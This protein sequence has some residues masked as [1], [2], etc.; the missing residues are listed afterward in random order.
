MAHATTTSQ[1]RRQAAA[2]ASNG[3]RPRRWLDR[4]S[5]N[6]LLKTVIAA[7]AAAVIVMLA[8]NAWDSW[9]KLR[10]A[11]EILAVAELSSHAFSAMNGLRTDRASTVR[12]L[13][14][15]APIQ[16]DMKSY[17]KKYRDADLPGARAVAEVVRKIEFKDQAALSAELD[18]SIKALAQLQS[19]SWD[20]LEKPKAARREQLGNEF[21]SETTKMLEV[22]DKI[23]GNAFA[24]IKHTNAY[25]DEMMEMK[26]LA[27]LV[28]NAGGEASVL[29]SNG[30]AAGKVPPEARQLYAGW[31]RATEQLWAALEDLAS[32]TQLP[33]PLASA[34]TGAKENYF[35]VKFTGMR[36]RLLNALINGEKPELTANQYSPISA[37]TRESLLAVAERALDAAKDQ[38]QALQVAAERQLFGQVML[39]ALALALAFGSMIAVN[40]RVVGP[41]RTICEAMLKLAGGDLNA[42]APFTH[43]QD[44]VGALAGALGT[45]RQNAIEKAQIEEEQRRRH[46]ET[47]TRQQTVDAAIAGFESQVKD[48]LDALDRASGEMRTTSDDMAK[49]STETT[50]QVKA[51]AAASEDASSNVQTVAAASEE[52]SASIA[53]ISRQVTHAANIAV[54]AVEETNQTDSTVRGLAES[55]GRIGEV[56]RLI[57]DIA[58]QTNLLALNATIE[59]ARAGEAGKGFAVV[60]SEVKSLATQTA[61][62]TE[63]IAAQVTEVQSVTKAAVEAI[64]RIGGTIDEVSTVATSIA[65]AV[66]QQGAATQEITRN[67]QQAARRTKDVSDGVA[68]VSA[69]ADATGQAAGGVKAAAEILGQQA[70][71]LRGQVD[72]FLGKIRA[73]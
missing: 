13:N 53:E 2:A 55:A 41:L 10:G 12:Y 51:A 38:G 70:E 67:T 19:E 15:P 25:I 43:R 73:A 3:A 6:A 56:V 66:E 23:S 57:S 17:V 22:L 16:S 46:A 71:R 59:A 36:E 42:D 61:K 24:A 1:D 48:A 32:G 72:D 62:A 30:L 33:R 29:V 34:I 26:Q 8:T 63:E 68:G 7:M 54:R 44:E 31:V 37:E 47:A 11:G 40:R 50:D 35:N 65:S 9:Q 14:D 58:G 69:G 5:A 45:F 27:W 52:L 49:T 39:F 20:A 18:R 21:A 28:R 64:K 4:L 60:A